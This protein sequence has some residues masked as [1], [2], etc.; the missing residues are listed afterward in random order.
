MQRT[1]R[2]VDQMVRCRFFVHFLASLH[3]GVEGQSH[4]TVIFIVFPQCQAVLDQWQ[5]IGDE[6]V[7]AKG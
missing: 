2:E 1:K 4:A 6:L 3:D 7:R 5:R